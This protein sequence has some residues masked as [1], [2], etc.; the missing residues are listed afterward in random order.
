VIQLNSHDI[1]NPDFSK[2]ISINII[3]KSIWYPTSLLKVN[4]ALGYNHRYIRIDQN[5]AHPADSTE[6][7]TKF[8]QLEPTVTA[9]ILL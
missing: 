2:F 3:R 6:Q 8:K 7:Q 1:G 5:R 9:E 4:I